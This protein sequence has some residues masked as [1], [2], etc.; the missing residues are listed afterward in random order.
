VTRARATLSLLALLVWAVAA[1]PRQ[2]ANAWEHLV[3][4]RQHV[5]DRVGTIRRE[6]YTPAFQAGI[7]RIASEIPPGGEYRVVES[8]DPG[9][10]SYW[11]R[12]ALVPRVPRSLGA[13]SALRPGDLQALL[14]R[15]P[16]VFVVGC[17]DGAPA[18]LR[19]GTATGEAHP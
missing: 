15:S 16:H 1:I 18:L 11:I 3:F 7:E 8:R 14:T 13:E 12:S 19:A 6:Q 9:C 2:A 17:V 5:L 10:F 4:A